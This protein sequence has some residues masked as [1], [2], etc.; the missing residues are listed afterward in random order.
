MTPAPKRRWFRFSLRTLFVAV[1]V[2]GCWLGYYLNW[3]RQRHALLD[4]PN[5]TASFLPRQLA[6][7][8]ALRLLGERGAKS[9]FLHYSWLS[10]TLSESDEAQR[11]LASRLFPE[12]TIQVQTGTVDFSDDPG[13]PASP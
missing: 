9:V 13:K 7:S 10:P 11:N 12:A 6:A 1:T 2:F 5:V 4:E 8:L 3:V